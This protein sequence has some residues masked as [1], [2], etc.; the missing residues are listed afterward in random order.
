MTTYRASLGTRGE[1]RRIAAEAETATIERVRPWRRQVQP[2][3]LAPHVVVPQWIRSELP[4]KPPTPP[5]P[6]PSARDVVVAIVGAMVEKACTD[7]EEKRKPPPQTTSRRATTRQSTEKM[8]AKMNDSVT[9]QEKEKSADE[10]NGKAEQFQQG[11]D[12]ATKTPE[13][14][15]QDAMQT[16]TAVDVASATAA[17][18]AAATA[19]PSAPEQSDPMDIDTQPPAP[20]PTS[21]P[22]SVPVQPPVSAPPSALASA[23]ATASAPAPAIAPIPGLPDPLEITQAN[24]QTTEP[25]AD[26]N[27]LQPPSVIKP[28]SDTAILQPENLAVDADRPDE[29]IGVEP[30]QSIAATGSGEQV[31]PVGSVP[32]SANVEYAQKQVNPEPAEPMNQAPETE[33]PCFAPDLPTPT[34]GPTAITE[35]APDVTGGVAAVGAGGSEVVQTEQAVSQ[36][37]PSTSVVSQPPDAAQTDPAQQEETGPNT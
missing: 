22:A 29:Q 3:K 15:A 4:P 25:S 17:A 11:T 35:A 28:A 10:A 13:I 20:V 34:V 9:Q 27:D 12:R 2:C 16:D 6:P 32:A 26:A 14:A 19:S 30:V 31:L 37:V 24:E 23:P 7:A 36:P 33:L 1:L 8:Q 21:T 5:P 18:A